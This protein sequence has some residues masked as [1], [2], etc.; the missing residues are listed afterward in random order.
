MNCPDVNTA[1]VTINW[2][3]DVIVPLASALIGGL[4]AL[5]GVHLTL[6][7]DALQREVEQKEKARPFFTILDDGD[8]RAKSESVCFFGFFH[9]ESATDVSLAINMINSEKNEFIIDKLSI[10]QKDYL[11][12]RKELVT[13][14][15]IFSVLVFDDS[16]IDLSDI[17]LYITDINHQHRI[18]KLAF[19]NDVIK[20]FVEL[21]NKEV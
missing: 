3:T 12:T 7:R 13:Q 2:V 4:M 6:K 21:E 15:L 8:A 20:E 19:E 18:Y 9:S 11:P 16:I 14:G 10:S 17:K 1:A 5:W